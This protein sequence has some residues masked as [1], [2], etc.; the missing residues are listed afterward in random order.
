M[1]HPSSFALV[2]HPAAPCPAVET[3]VVQVALMAGGGLSLAYRLKG[4]LARLNIPAALPSGPADSLWEHTCFEAFV[5]VAGSRAY[6]EFNF[7]PSGQWAAYAF[8][9]YRQRDESL[10]FA[11]GV[12]EIAVRRFPDRLELDAVLDRALLPEAEAAAS[13]QLGLSAVVEG[14]DGS[15]SYWALAHPDARPDFHHRGAFTVN[16]AAAETKT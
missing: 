15:R 16:L 8:S 12:P 11:L 2:C 14:A 10:Q 3:I 9:G 1:F 4:D 6:R 5:G 7:S 13:F